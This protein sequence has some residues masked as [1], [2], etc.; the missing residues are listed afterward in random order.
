MLLYSYLLTP[1]STKCP[2]CALSSAASRHSRSHSTYL[3]SFYTCMAQVGFPISSWHASDQHS[4][5]SL[6]LTNS[7]TLSTGRRMWAKQYRDGKLLKLLAEDKHYR[8]DRP[9]IH[10]FDDN[11]IEFRPGSYNTIHNTILY[12]TIT[13]AT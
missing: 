3:A 9:V 1:K 2:A 7:R 12:I 5:P 8:Y 13:R 4:S 11:P 10:R 6:S